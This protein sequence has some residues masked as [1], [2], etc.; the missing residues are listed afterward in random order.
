MSESPSARPA[1]A[2]ALAAI[3]CC[4]AVFLPL[5]WLACVSHRPPAPQDARAE[6]LPADQAWKATPASRRAYIAG[7]RDRQAAQLGSYGWIDRDAGV[8][9]LPI[10]RAMDLVVRQYGDRGPSSQ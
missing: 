6:G 7:L 2:A 4:L 8:V 10:D 3:F 1:N 9:Q 5:T